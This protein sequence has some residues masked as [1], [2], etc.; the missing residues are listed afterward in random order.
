MSK[1]LIKLSQA[2][3]ESTMLEQ[4]KVVERSI[5]NNKINN[6]REKYPFI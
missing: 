6:F 5:T 2:K 3:L 1:L 4:A